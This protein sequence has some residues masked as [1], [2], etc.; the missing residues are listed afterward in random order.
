MVKKIGV[1]ADLE[2]IQSAIESI[3]KFQNEIA[4]NPAISFHWAL[5][6]M[7]GELY[8]ALNLHNFDLDVTLK[9]KRHSFDI[10]TKKQRFEVKTTKKDELETEIG[11]DHIKPKNFDAL[12]LVYLN[13][14][15]SVK[16]MKW[17]SSEQVKDWF[18][19]RAIAWKRIEEI[20]E[21]DL[22][23]DL[24]IAYTKNNNNER[25]KTRIKALDEKFPSEKQSYLSRYEEIVNLLQLDV[26]F[27]PSHE[28][29]SE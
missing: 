5:T 1:K 25:W 21:D 19:P 27:N 29:I 13:S 10:L 26:D 7:I 4:N 8:V 23:T 22:F 2:E 6:G 9:Q 20:K 11:F 28:L 14:D 16:K 24:W 18:L 12:V 15:L 3:K 17:F